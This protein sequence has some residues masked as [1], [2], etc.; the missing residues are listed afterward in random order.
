MHCDHVPAHLGV[1]LVFLP[2]LGGVPHDSLIP[3]APV[4]CVLS[5]AIVLELLVVHARAAI[6]GAHRAQRIV[7]D[8]VAK[9]HGHVH[10]DASKV[11]WLLVRET[12]EGTEPERCAGA[13]E[14]CIASLEQ[15]LL[16][17]QGWGCVRSK[18]WVEGAGSTGRTPASRWWAGTWARPGNL[19]AQRR[20]Q[21]CS[22]QEADQQRGGRSPRV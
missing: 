17:D 12:K 21:R 4:I 9:L 14:G 7:V 10:Q 11:C 20:Q 18:C 6:L 13:K 19:R 2:V 16:L 5:G 22:R 1:P 15:A 3:S 8:V